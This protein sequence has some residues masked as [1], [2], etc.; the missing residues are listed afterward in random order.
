MAKESLIW[1]H[2]KTI[3]PETIEDFKAATVAMDSGNYDEAIRLYRAVLKKAPDSHHVL[4]RLGTSLVMKGQLEEGLSFIEQAIIKNRSA[5][6]L[7]TMALFLAYPGENK[8]G[9]PDQKSQAFAVIKEAEFL[10]KT[11]DDPDVDLLLSQ[12][13]YDFGDMVTFRRATE[14]LSANH[15]ELMATHFFK[16][17]L[18]AYDGNWST[19]ETEI[20]RAESMGLAP[21][22]AQEFLAQTGI[23]GRNRTWRYSMYGASVVG[24][25]LVGLG[26]L[27]VF[28]KLMSKRTLRSIEEADPNAGTSNADL[29][30][31][32]WYR[33]LISIAGIY[34]YLSIP[35]VIFL[36][37]G[38]AAAATYFS[39]VLGHIPI[40]W[41]L[42]LDIGAV[43]TSYKM[44]RSL[45]LKIEQEDPGR[46]LKVDEA[47]GLWELAR[48]V[49]ETVKTR[50]VDE[51]RITP[52]TEL[53]VYERGSWREK[54]S[55]RAHRI[56]ILGAGVLNDFKLNSF[57]A[58]LAHEYG[59]FSHRDTAG[60]EIALRVNSDMLKFAHAMI[61][62]GQN[63]WWN[64]AFH[65]LR[66][67]DFIFR[68]LSHGAT[69]L[70]EVLADRVA[71]T[72]YGAAAFEEGLRHVIRRGAEFDVSA[73]KEIA[74]AA[75]R[76][77]QN[78]YELPITAREEVESM[79]RD[80]LTRVTSE[81]DT[82][83]SPLDRFRYVER[84]TSQ[85]EAQISGEVWDLFKDRAGLT[86]EMTSK[87]QQELQ[88][89]VIA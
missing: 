50:P 79:A 42:L 30:L 19:A 29:G 18:A 48:S 59:H 74:S 53:A 45:F 46:P 22:V 87:V 51:I 81:D 17:L 23:E 77:L 61:L 64:L 41:L 49:A 83:P 88:S 2:L 10:P 16:A 32:K 13:A 27:F 70:Q 56:L 14:R 54:S 31:R 36:V 38:A 73:N 43:I 15:Q 8:E 75:G 40:K 44:I 12:L 62:S 26:A 80:S 35:F 5:D 25:W 11:G 68:R 66:I 89:Y 52:G 55:D 84:I 82:H 3:A 86:A 24:V 9:T 39:F 71:A 58:V 21:N 57:R 4:R 34:Y 76:A 1:D 78:L 67:Y 28:G 20:K 47:P 72:K 63:V 7:Y 37:L 69:R 65:F 6:N 85:T 33:R 60:G